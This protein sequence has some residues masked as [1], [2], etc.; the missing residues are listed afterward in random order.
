MHAI[1][2][3]FRKEVRDAV[4]SRWMVAFALTFGIVALVLSLVQ[5]SSDNIGAQGFNRT[6]AA[7]TNLSLLLVPLLA[8]VVGAGAIA[9]ER[10][11]GTWTT[12]LAQ[13]ITVGQLII[14]KFA[15][16]LIAIWATIALGF[17]GAG[18]IVGLISPIT[19]VGHYL[20]FSILS[21]VLAAATLSIGTLISVFSDGRLKALSQAMVVW[22]VLVVLYDLAA[23]G[24]ALNFSASGRSLLVAVLANP[25]EC[26]RIFFILSLEPDLDV[27]GPLGSYVVNEVGTSSAVGL[28]SGM[29]VGWILIPLMVTIS[30]ARSQDA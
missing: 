28:L 16:L 15:G 27:L 22:F 25:V 21:A 14:G 2:V 11:R 7:L 19:D 18:M 5:A 17:G 30:V 10:E 26:V 24:L 4:R 3:I 8:L 13:P 9:G 20:L 12:L 1:G 23:V 6:T 29:L